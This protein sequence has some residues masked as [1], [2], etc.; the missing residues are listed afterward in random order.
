M[1]NFV[2]VMVGGSFGAVCRF[3]FSALVKRYFSTEFPIATLSI[4]MIGSFLLGLLVAAHPG[5]FNQLL[6]GTGFMGGFTTYSTFQLENV[7][8]FTK[9]NYKSLI[10]Y[11]TCSFLLCILLAI[12]GLYLG[13]FIYEK[14]Y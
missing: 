9:K 1:I 5:S 8:L 3:A 11:I 7:T 10:I 12:S 2:M 13:N 4:N 6:L 14:L